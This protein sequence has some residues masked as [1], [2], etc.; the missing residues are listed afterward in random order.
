MLCW[1]GGVLLTII[2]NHSDFVVGL[3]LGIIGL[4]I[5]VLLSIWIFKRRHSKNYK[6]EIKS[7]S[8][9]SQDYFDFLKKNFLLF[10]ILFFLVMAITGFAMVVTS[11]A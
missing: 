4:I 11:L 10:L 7:N 2:I 8:R 6:S 3:S 5:A 9:P 1:R